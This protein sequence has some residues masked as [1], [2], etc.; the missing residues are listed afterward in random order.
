[1]SRTRK[2]NKPLCE[3]ISDI[4]PMILMQCVWPRKNWCFWKKNNVCEE[5][6][7]IGLLIMETSCN[8]NYTSYWKWSPTLSETI[9]PTTEKKHGDSSKKLPPLTECSGK[10]SLGHRTDVLYRIANCKQRYCSHLQNSLIHVTVTN[11]CGD[12]FS[13]YKERVVKTRIN[14][15]LLGVY[16][17]SKNMKSSK[18]TLQEIN[19][20][21]L[22]KRK[23]IFKMD[24]SG[25]MLV[26]RNLWNL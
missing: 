17:C 18:H 24:F 20:S 16:V 22:G 23:I 3:T 14:T 10:K 7:R 4:V 19:I 2:G 12:G 13:W 15:F 21:H 5:V 6:G 26:P 11:R 9:H 1:M 25:D 8:T